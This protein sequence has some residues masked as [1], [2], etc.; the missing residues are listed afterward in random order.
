MKKNKTVSKST[1][2][3]A[4]RCDWVPNP[5]WDCSDIACSECRLCN[6]LWSCQDIGIKATSWLQGKV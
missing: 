4:K 5:A 1:Q 6:Q 3:S 2:P